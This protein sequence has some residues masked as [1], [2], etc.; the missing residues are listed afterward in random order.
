[1]YR[2]NLPSPIA[3]V[4]VACDLNHK[5]PDPPLVELEAIARSDRP[6]PERLRPM[7]LTRILFRNPGPVPPGTSARLPR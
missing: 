5:S 1:L 7:L 2:V 3:R 4:V 6:A